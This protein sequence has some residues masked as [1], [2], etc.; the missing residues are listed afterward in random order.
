MKTVYTLLL[1][2]IP[3][4][5]LSQD[6]EINDTNSSL[7][8]TIPCK[9]GCFKE[10]VGLINLNGTLQPSINSAC[11]SIGELEMV[12]TAG[13]TGLYEITSPSIVFAP[14]ETWIYIQSESS[15]FREIQAQVQPNGKIFIQA[16][17]N[18]VLT[19]LAQ[20]NISFKIIVF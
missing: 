19:N 8:S 4:T 3:L 7:K 6:L 20:E 9:C 5:T 1:V 12:K 15:L 10:A 11:S 18:G 2:L 14:A 16:Y 17:Q 13:F